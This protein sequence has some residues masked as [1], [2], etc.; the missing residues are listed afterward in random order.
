VHCFLTS[1]S[2][3]KSHHRN[4]ARK[5]KGKKGLDTCYRRGLLFTI[6][7]N[8]ARIVYSTSETPWFR[9]P[10]CL[11]SGKDGSPVDLFLLLCKRQKVLYAIPRKFMVKLCSGQLHNPRFYIDVATDR[12]HFFKHSRSIHAYR[13]S[14]V[15]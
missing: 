1:S 8:T 5:A 11:S 4:L 13:N 14:A 7:G 10:K 3:Y 2:P 9:I 6:N 15:S 12:C